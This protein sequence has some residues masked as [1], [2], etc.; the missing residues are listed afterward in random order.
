MKLALGTVQFGLAYGI[1]GPGQAVAAAEA[2]RILQASWS[3]GVRTLDTAAAYGDIEE[4]LAGLCDGLPF[5]VVSKVPA[6]PAGLSD[7][8]AASWAVEQAQL[9]RQR[10]G[11]LLAGL[12]CHRAEDLLGVRGA[13]IHA[14]LQAWAEPEGVVLGASCYDPATLLALVQQRQIRIAQLP[15]N[16]LDQRL[17]QWIPARQPGLEIHLRSAFLQGLLLMPGPVGARRLP[18]AAAALQRW[19][20]WCDERGLGPLQAALSAVKSFAAVSEVVVG[21][22]S[23]AQFD[24]IAEAWSSVHPI[25]CPELAEASAAIIDPRAWT[26]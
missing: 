3:Q 15:G 20:A 9:S 6:V 4:R 21:V 14:A 5:R 18:V 11:P 26:P 25:A 12:M 10:L 7:A 8:V 22:D 13:A 24:A 19:Q 2:R 1:A 23:L 16:A 17:V